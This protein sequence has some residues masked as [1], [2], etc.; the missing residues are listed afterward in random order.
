[1]C[2]TEAKRSRVGEAP[3]RETESLFKIGKAIAS[4]LMFLSQK[5]KGAFVSESALHSFDGDKPNSVGSRKRSGPDDHS[6]H[7]SRT[8]DECPANFHSS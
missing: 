8:R 5:E 7:P 1:V 6:S 4:T 2:V 3:K